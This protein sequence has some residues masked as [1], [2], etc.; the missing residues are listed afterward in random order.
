MAGTGITTGTSA[1]TFSPNAP[2]T[3]AQAVTFLL[4]Y[5]NLLNSPG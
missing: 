3:R 5:T 2:L 4:R 1:T